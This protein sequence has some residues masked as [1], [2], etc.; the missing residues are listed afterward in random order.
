MNDY[1]YFSLL[2]DELTEDMDYMPW[3]E[4]V[5]K[6]KGELL[7]VGCGSG[8]LLIMLHQLGYDCT[9]LDLSSSMID[10]AKKKLIMNHININLLVDNML[11]FNL[12]KKFD[13]IT[14]FF[15]TINHLSN[16]DDVKQT[17]L[18][19]EKHLS[20]EGVILVDLFTGEKMKDINEE[21][22]IFD[23]NTY[24]AKWNMRCNETTITHNLYFKIGTDE[25]KEEYIETYFDIKKILPNTL[26]LIKE[27]PIIVDN[28]CERIVY[29]IKK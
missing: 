2:Y 25:I 28:V 15:D 13:I 3:I 24:Y 12:D 18:N 8:S 23:E 17:L 7:D 5:S 21:T 19:F 9:G 4:I 22:F 16:E 6:F 14:C 10:L 26:T 1:K 27:I 11:N 29:V 20:N